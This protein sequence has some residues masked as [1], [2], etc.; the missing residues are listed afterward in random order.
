MIANLGALRRAS[1]A[2]ASACYEVRGLAPALGSLLYDPVI[3]EPS[4]QILLDWA[5]I[6]ADPAS[7][8]AFALSRLGRVL[9]AMVRAYIASHHYHLE[10]ATG[11]DQDADRLVLHDMGNGAVV[12]RVMMLLTEVIAPAHGA[13]GRELAQESRSD[14]ARHLFGVIDRIGHR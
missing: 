9:P 14:L 6:A 12:G 13:A 1:P 7:M 5:D 10:R 8:R 4:L 11:Q 2:V 3:P